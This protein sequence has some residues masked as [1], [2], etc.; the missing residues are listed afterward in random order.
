MSAQPEVTE[1]TK[2]AKAKKPMFQF[3]TESQRAE[4]ALKL[5]QH[6]RSLME[7]EKPEARTQFIAMSLRQ[8]ISCNINSVGDYVLCV[9]GKMEPTLLIAAEDVIEAREMW[10]TIKEEILMGYQMQETPVREK[11]QYK[12]RAPKAVAHV[13]PAPETLTFDFSAPAESTVGQAAEV[14]KP[15][16]G[17]KGSTVGHAAE[18]KKQEASTVEKP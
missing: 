10:V 1:T 13:D 9:V 12:P 17:K 3:K 16:A 8:F 2:Q 15:K 11:R 7:G 5:R 6:Y 14:E 4:S 18:V